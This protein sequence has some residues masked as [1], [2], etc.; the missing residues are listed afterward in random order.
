[1]S[2]E[3]VREFDFSEKDFRR[4]RELIKTRAGIDLGTQKQSLV[5]GRL[6]RRLRVLGLDSFARYLDK[7][8]D[9]GGD[10]AGRFVNAITTNVTEFFRE[11]H[12][13]EFLARTALPELWA[14]LE[15]TGKRARF[16]SAGC[17]TGEEPYSLAMV[18]RENMPTS[19]GWDIKIL[20]TDL[21]TDVLAQANAGEYPAERVAKIA[22]ARLARF[23]KA[24]GGGENFHAGDSLRSLITFKQLNLMEAWPMQGPMNVIFCRN[25]VIYFDEATKQRLIGRYR[26]LLAPGGLLFLGHSESLAGGAVGLVQCGKTIHRKNPV[27]G[28]GPP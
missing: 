19:P 22:P 24:D 20:A 12:H 23:F 26:D 21:D 4:V 17:S 18:V 16:W 6:A 5:Y 25:V 11:N 8:E 2:Y 27:A 10:E 7:V 28:L 3:P 15:K 1:M 13:F 14:R 9:E